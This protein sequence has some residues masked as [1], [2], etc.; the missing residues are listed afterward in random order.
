[1][2]GVPS[3]GI[4]GG[5]LEVK[6]GLESKFP[7]PISQTYFKLY[8]YGSDFIEQFKRFNAGEEVDVSKLDFYKKFYIIHFNNVNW[9]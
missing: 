8:N 6:T 2:F 4:S 5:M 7:S 9:A 1:M 3:N